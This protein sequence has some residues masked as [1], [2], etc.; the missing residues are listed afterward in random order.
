[1]IRRLCLQFVGAQKHDRVSPILGIL[2]ALEEIFTV[3]AVNS[4]GAD[5]SLTEQRLRKHVLV[6]DYHRPRLISAHRNHEHVSSG[7]I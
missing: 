4:L 6:A 7:N 1:M 5:R 3:C 2:A